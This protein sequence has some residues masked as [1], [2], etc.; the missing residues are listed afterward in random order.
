MRL[1]AWSTTSLLIPQ[2]RTSH[3]AAGMTSLALHSESR[4]RASEKKKESPASI[5]PAGL[6]WGG[7]PT[8]QGQDCG[9]V[10]HSTASAAGRAL[11]E[12]TD[13][14]CLAEPAA[15]AYQRLNPSASWAD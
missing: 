3:V 1:V 7:S 14:R 11:F 6:V 4:S 9:D 12:L 15:G 8:K 5:L 13:F 10:G 2:D